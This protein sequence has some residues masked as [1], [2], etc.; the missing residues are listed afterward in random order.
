MFSGSLVLLIAGSLLA[1]DVSKDDAVKKDLQLLQGEWIMVSSER[2]G[3]KVPEER[4]KTF[5]RTVT[6]NKFT[7]TWEGE[8][9][10][11]T[12]SGVM[13]I[14]P[15]QKPKTVDVLFT[16]GP[17]KDKT[18]QAIY[19]VEGDTFTICLG[20]PDEGRPPDFDSKHGSLNVW[21]RAKK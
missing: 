1:S 17:S 21:K 2:D 4:I 3:E 10:A 19:K 6:G 8:D 16:E 20:K 5:K 18:F 11:H 12:V 13:T 9:G 15:T 7:V 14:D